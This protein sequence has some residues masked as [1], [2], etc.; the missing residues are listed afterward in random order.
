V[1]ERVG[2][3]LL[4]C[5]P[6]LVGGSEEY[7]ARQLAGVAD[8]GPDDVDLVLFA[9][10]GYS[11][12]HPELTGRLPIVTAPLTGSRRSVRVAF[13]HTWLPARARE[14][15]IDLLH[16]AGGTL[17]RPQP[18][19]GLVTIHDL[20]Y[21]S[22]PQYF[23]RL[24]LAWLA[25]AV[26]AAVEHAVTVTVPSEYVKA[27][28]VDAFNCPGERVAV[29]PHGLGARIDAPAAPD[30]LRARYGIAERFILYPA[31]THPHK[32]HVLLVRAFVALGPRYDDVALVLLGG[33]G[34]AEGAVRAEIE[35]LGVS[36][37]VIRPGRIPA[38]DRDGLYRL[39]TVLA[40]PSQYEGFGAPV[41]EAMA[42]GCPV[43][44]A[45]A[46]AL[47]EVVSDAGLLLD[48]ASVDEW[49]DVLGALIDDESERGR[50]AA[51]GRR[52][53]AHF[54]AAASARALLDAYRLSFSLR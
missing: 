7:V 39:A 53:A 52:R 46:A 22:Y 21:L 50:L 34:A 44:A 18:A 31:I 48:S 38:A 36:D 30:D 37:R 45:R 27:T 29:V 32:N 13:E 24:K 47:P 35:R 16:H 54:T 42:Y 4:W 19:P 8:A 14:W 12:A 10:R 6:G 28:V 41:L 2:V 11:D 26:P 5:L 23:G 9:A 43:V 3:N 20:Q 33:A 51:A 49:R 15:R 17:P 25:S 40:F 1:S